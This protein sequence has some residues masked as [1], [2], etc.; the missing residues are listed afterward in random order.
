LPRWTLSQ[1]N[2]H[3][4]AVF[5]EEVHTGKRLLNV[6]APVARPA[7][8]YNYTLMMRHGQDGLQ[9]LPATP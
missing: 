7:F 5:D 3:T 9:R 1:S 8:R 4:V 6:L 2:G